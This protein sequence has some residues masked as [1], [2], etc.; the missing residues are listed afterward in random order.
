MK[1]LVLTVAFV[2]AAACTSWR[3]LE[4][5]GVIVRIDPRPPAPIAGELGAEPLGNA[6]APA[7]ST[8]G[9]IIVVRTARGPQQL[10]AG[11][12]AAAEFKVGDQVAICGLENA[13]GTRARWQ[14]LKR[15]SPA[16]PAAAPNPAIASLLPPPPVPARP[17]P[18]TGAFPPEAA[19]A[20]AGARPDRPTP[21]TP[22]QQP[23]RGL[24]ALA[25]L[26][27]PASSPAR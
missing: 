13:S 18:L 11:V 24:V 16:Q 1:R 10:V 4:L 22:P 5:E 19:P 15:R 27:A 3:P 6:P 25:S 23:A 9:W 17:A 14:L 20:P 2:A 26:Q 12:E 21:L 7:T 8:S